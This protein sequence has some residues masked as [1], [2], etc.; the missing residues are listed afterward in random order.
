MWPLF[1][2]EWPNLFGVLDNIKIRHHSTYFRKT[3][4]SRFQPIYISNADIWIV[5]SILNRGG[6]HIAA[7]GAIVLFLF[8]REHGS[9]SACVALRF[10]A[11]RPTAVRKG[12]FV[13]LPGTYPFGARCA[14]RAVPGYCQP[15]LAGLNIHQQ[16]R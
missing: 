8:V 4:K 6:D 3:E 1:G 11:R 12:L 5:K 2:Q 15:S 14:P 9:C 13:C 7:S 10:A 16:S